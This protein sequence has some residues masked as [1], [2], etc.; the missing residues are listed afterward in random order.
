VDNELNLSV[1][2]ARFN[3]DETGATAYDPRILFKIILYAYSRGIV[4]SRKIAQS[5][6][7][8]V[9][10][11]GAWGMWHGVGPRQEVEIKE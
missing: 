10:L 1:F 7:E 4:S 9:V 5:C 11:H 2:D 6:R 8:N 3:N